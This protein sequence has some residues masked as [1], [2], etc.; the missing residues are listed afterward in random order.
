MRIS[1]WSSDVCSSD[2]EGLH[3]LVIL[4]ADGSEQAIAFDDPAYAIELPLE[5]AYDAASVL[6]AHQSPKSPRRWIGVDLARGKQTVVQQQKVENFDPD[7][8]QRSE[9]HT[10]ELQSL[11]RITYAG[12]R[13]KKKKRPRNRIHTDNAKV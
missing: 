6:I 4:R 9:E 3:R 7:D 13:L 2:L 5:P 11:M 10:S 1:D 12:L 8:Y